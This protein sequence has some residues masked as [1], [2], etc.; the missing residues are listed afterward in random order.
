MEHL[1]PTPRQGERIDIAALE[2]G[3]ELRLIVAQ[4]PDHLEVVLTP[5]HDPAIAMLGAQDHDLDGLLALPSAGA[6]DIELAVHHDLVNAG[7]GAPA[8]TPKDAQEDRRLVLLAF[9]V[10]V[11]RT[12]RLGR[13]QQLDVVTISG[14]HGGA[15]LLLLRP[16]P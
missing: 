3:D 10:D 8:G 11:E 9:E 7:R 1:R 4:P 12:K 14:L 6:G 16:G 2:P 5:R 15:P 13:R